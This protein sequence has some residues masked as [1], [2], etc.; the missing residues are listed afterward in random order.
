MNLSRL[1]PLTVPKAVYPLKSI[2]KR[3]DSSKGLYYIGEDLYGDEFYKYSFLLIHLFDEAMIT[4]NLHALSIEQQKL[5]EQY[6]LEG[7]TITPP[8]TLLD[9]SSWVYDFDSLSVEINQLDEF[10]GSYFGEHHG[11]KCHKK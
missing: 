10:L 3:L 2:F 11:R 1:I 4:N 7:N 8:D 9:L 5:L 6:F